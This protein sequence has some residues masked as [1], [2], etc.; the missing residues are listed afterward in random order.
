MS[1]TT[2][3]IDSRE[4]GML[5]LAKKFKIPHTVEAMK[6]GDY[7]LRNGAEWICVIERKTVADLLN[8]VLSKQKRKTKDDY[9]RFTSQLNAMHAFP[10]KVKA[11]GIV[12][13]V[14]KEDENLFYGSL[15][16]ECVRT[17]DFMFWVSTNERFLKFAYTF[18]RKVDEGK[19]RLPMRKKREGYDAMRVLMDIGVGEK[20]A[21]R[22][23]GKYET[24]LTIANLNETD[25]KKVAT[26]QAAK[27]V[28]EFFRRA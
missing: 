5:T 6:V 28:Y 22:I 2:I 17:L 11:M 23:V 13:I 4:Q 26:R 1:K 25:L 12:G 7:G 27:K 16:S 14:K 3:I 9:H 20:N 8:A 19:W 18:L 21:S 15:A 24:L 10:C